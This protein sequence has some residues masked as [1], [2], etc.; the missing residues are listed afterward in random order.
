METLPTKS[1]GG[2]GGG[3]GLVPWGL[4]GWPAAS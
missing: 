1:N 3:S 4:C 2:M